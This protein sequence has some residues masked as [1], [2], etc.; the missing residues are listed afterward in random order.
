MSAT[1]FLKETSALLGLFVM[2][3]LWSIVGLA[4]QG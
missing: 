4:L 3:Y 2:L 1:A